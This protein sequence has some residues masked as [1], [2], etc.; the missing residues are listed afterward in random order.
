VELGASVH[1]GGEGGSWCRS[2]WKRMEQLLLWRLRVCLRSKD[3]LGPRCTG[4]YSDGRSERRTERW[5]CV[6]DGN[7]V[8]PL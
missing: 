3:E 6:V 5:S 7:G 2:G 4:C 1:D 8:A